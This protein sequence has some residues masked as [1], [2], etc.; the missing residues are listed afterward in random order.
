MSGR[1]RDQQSLHGLAAVLQVSQTLGD[2]VAPRKALD[3][4]EVI[5]YDLPRPLSDRMSRRDP[6]VPRLSPS[7]GTPAPPPGTS[8]MPFLAAASQG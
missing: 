1:D 7:D 8:W 4:H 5:P 2:Q 6:V 3:L